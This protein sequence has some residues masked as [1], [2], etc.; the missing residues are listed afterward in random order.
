MLD[1]IILDPETLNKRRKL[2]AYQLD[3]IFR[4]FQKFSLSKG[5]TEPIQHKNSFQNIAFRNE[6]GNS[7]ILLPENIYKQV[8]YRAQ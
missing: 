7:L 3:T 5:Y 2:S 4:Q 1:F 8:L 6:R